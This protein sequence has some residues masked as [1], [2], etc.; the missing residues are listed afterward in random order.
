[1]APRVVVV[2][3]VNVDLVLRLP[4]LPA[5]GETV[6]GGS[7]SVAQGGKGANAASAAAR[8]GAD[9]QLVGATGDDEHGRAARADLAD[10]G[11]GLE[12]LAAVAAATGVAHVLV[13]AAGENLIGVASGA[14]AH[15][16]AAAAGASV[17]ACARPGD[18]VLACL[19]V[20]MGAVAAAAEAASEAGAAFVL[21]PAPA[22]PLPAELVP[23][24]AVIKGNRGEIEA[25]GHAGAAGLLAAGAAAVIVTEGPR[26]CTIHRREIS[27]HVA[28]PV[29]EAID[30]TGAGDAFAGALAAALAGGE[31]LEAA[32]RLASAAGAHATLALGARASLATRAQAEA[33]SG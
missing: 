14:N 30:A 1:V 33:L 7:A 32:V 11:V 20:P 15:L 25:L 27:V 22:A 18:A 21:D 28:A 31:P 5:P 24:C 4:R 19:E 16:S 8:F 10:F 12:H 17:R 29:V 9:V 2:G 23:H 3:S 6:T 13:D 26:G